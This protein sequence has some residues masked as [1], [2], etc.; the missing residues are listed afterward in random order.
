MGH[1]KDFD[2]GL[3]L[4]GYRWRILISKM[5][6]SDLHLKKVTLVFAGRLDRRQEGQ[7]RDCCRSSGGTWS[8]ME[9]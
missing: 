9:G 5:I 6:Y 2:F 3:R 7:L 1:Y 8:R 4:V